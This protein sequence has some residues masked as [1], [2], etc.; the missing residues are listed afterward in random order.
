M[1][2]RI[3]DVITI[4]FIAVIFAAM[5][6][7]FVFVTN[8]L[9]RVFKRTKYNEPIMLAINIISLLISIF[10]IIYSLPAFSRGFQL[11]DF[12]PYYGFRAVIYTSAITYLGLIPLFLISIST[13]ISTTYT[14]VKNKKQTKI[15]NG[16]EKK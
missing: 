8:V 1:S 15:R 16:E 5:L 13:Y 2:I 10:P 14:I 9:I 11:D 3:Y 7:I 12:V 6:A 4:M